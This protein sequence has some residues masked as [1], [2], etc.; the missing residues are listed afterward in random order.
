[1]LHFQ[2]PYFLPHCEMEALGFSVNLDM[3]IICIGRNYVAHIQELGNQ[4]P[5]EPVIFLK[6]KTSLVTPG[7]NM[8]YP[9]FSR[10]LHY[11]GELVLHICKNGRSI[12]RRQVHEFYD[13]LT[14]GIDFTARDVQDKLKQKGLPWEKAKAFDQSAAIGRFI[15]AADLKNPRNIQFQLHKNGEL[16]QDGHSELMLH[17]FEDIICHASEYFTLNI[18]DLI[19]T[20]TPAGVGPCEPTDRLEGFIEGQKLLELE[21]I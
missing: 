14:V 5:E 1:M 17:S 11:E 21:I 6:P 9:H 7:H 2:L 8:H 4:V 15:P 10:N 12:P 18:G 20:G 3:K 19:F 13:Q 16:V